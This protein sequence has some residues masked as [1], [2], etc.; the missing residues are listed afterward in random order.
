MVLPCTMG[1]CR[2]PPGSG[3][4]AHRPSADPEVPENPQRL[5]NSA[6]AT[7]SAA[8]ERD[9][10]ATIASLRSAANAWLSSSKRAADCGSTLREA[11]GVRS[12]E[13]N[14]LLSPHL[15]LTGTRCGEKSVNED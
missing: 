13:L 10:S 14:E 8:M 1:M 7:L 4:D 6:N 3:Q 12:G 15:L 5:G 9:F 2:A 11:A